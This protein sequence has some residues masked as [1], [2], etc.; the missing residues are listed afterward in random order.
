[1]ILAS[2]WSSRGTDGAAAHHRRSL[3]LEQLRHRHMLEDGIWSFAI[4]AGDHSLLCSLVAATAVAFSWR[5]P[6]WRRRAWQTVMN[7]HGIQQ[8]I[9][10]V[11]GDAF[12]RLPA[13]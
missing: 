7:L 8:F 6:C 12:A 1:M 2:F 9:T 5:L 13:G 4:V 10:E 11:Y 3:K